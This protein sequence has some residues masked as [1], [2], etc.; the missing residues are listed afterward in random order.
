MI[1]KFPKEKAQIPLRFITEI[2]Q[3]LYVYMYGCKKIRTV[4]LETK[5]TEGGRDFL[6]RVSLRYRRRELTTPHPPIHPPPPSPNPPPPPPP[7]P[8]N[9]TPHPHPHHPPPQSTGAIISLGTMEYEKVCVIAYKN[10]S[11][12]SCK[13]HSGLHKFNIRICC[14]MHNIASF[15]W[16]A[17]TQHED[18]PLLVGDGHEHFCAVCAR[19]VLNYVYLKTH[20]TF[21]LLHAN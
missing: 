10:N 20:A 13:Y 1:P 9:P 18:K 6:L 11:L 2:R 14:S 7:N 16:K 3:L 17:V 5:S 19:D 15:C 4:F 8:P 12:L 21:V